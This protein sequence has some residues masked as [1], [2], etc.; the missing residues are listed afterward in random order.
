MKRRSFMRAFVVILFLLFTTGG[1]SEAKE[2]IDPF[3]FIASSYLV[4]IDGKIVWAKDIHKRLPPASLTKIMT[5]LIALEKIRP[6][7]IVRVSR[8]A[9][10]EDGSRIRLKEGDRLRAIDLICA[11]LIHSANDACRAIA[12]Y[13]GGS[14]SNFVRM[15]NLRAQRMGLKNTN[16]VNS[17]G[18]DHPNHYSSAYDLMILTE[19][20][21]RNQ[22]FARIVSIPEMEV[23][24]VDGK[25]TFKL[26]NKNKLIDC[27]PG[28]IGVKTGYTDR[29]GR[30]LVAW[31]ERG[32][33][34]VLLILLNAPNRWDDAPFL[35]DLAFEF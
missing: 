33:R 17:C 30:C 10:M 31:A 5:A 34:K 12:E 35:L 1:F 29:A 6:D 7:E 18:H 4:K 16:F 20:A 8:S 24:T 25:R 26:K 28:V 2:L 13:V 9:A 19:A 22:A 15:M 32:N 27:Y 11:A 14:E 3:P 23:K 21:M